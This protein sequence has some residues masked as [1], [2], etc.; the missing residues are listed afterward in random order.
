LGG[1]NNETL[2][3]AAAAVFVMAL[4]ANGK[5]QCLEN[6][7]DMR[8]LGDISATPVGDAAVRRV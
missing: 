2:Y 3:T 8:W 6:N 1:H 4:P 5:A 7:S